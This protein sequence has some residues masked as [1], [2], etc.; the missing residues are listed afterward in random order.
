MKKLLIVLSLFTTFSL[1]ACN[2]QEAAPDD[3]SQGTITVYQEKEAL[4]KENDDLKQKVSELEASTNNQKNEELMENI[5]DTLNLSFKV[6]SAMSDKDFDYLQS[7]AAPDVKISKDSETLTT[8]I[9]E[10]P[11]LKPINLKELEYRGYVQESEDKFQI[12]LARVSPD[13]SSELYIDFIK[14]SNGWKYNGHITN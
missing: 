3:S 13:G 2:N 6:L 4:Q 7:V 10:I 12:A 5:R 14:S 1:A 9:G 11:L 8:E